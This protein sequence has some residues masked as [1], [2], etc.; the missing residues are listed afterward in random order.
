MKEN[1]VN[2]LQNISFSQL[3]FAEAKTKNLGR[4]TS[5][6]VISLSSSSRIQNYM[7]KFSATLYVLCKWLGGCAERNAVL[8]L[9]RIIFLAPT[10]P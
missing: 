9:K 10:A 3:I 1:N 6:F 7:T 8:G 2:Y 5:D 4:E